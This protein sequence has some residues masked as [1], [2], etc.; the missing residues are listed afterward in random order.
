MSHVIS[1]ICDR[2]FKCPR[3]NCSFGSGDPIAMIVDGN[4]KRRYCEDCAFKLNAKL[5]FATDAKQTLPA[6][7]APATLTELNTTIETAIRQRM[8]ELTQPQPDL[9]NRIV[10]IESQITR[11]NERITELGR[12]FDTALKLKTRN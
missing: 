1:L 8:E 2:P 11:L 4:S 5:S 3:C 6:T 10:D 9:L 12:Q 7:E